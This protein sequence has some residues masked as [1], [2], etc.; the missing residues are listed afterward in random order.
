[1]RWLAGKRQTK[2]GTDRMGEANRV[3]ESSKGGDKQRKRQTE[4]ACKGKITNRE[5]E[6]L[7]G[8][9]DKQRK[10]EFARERQTRE[11]DSLKR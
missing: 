2:Q 8:K 4:K 9:D 1:M 5:R 3:R 7:L 11:S 10:G 6:S